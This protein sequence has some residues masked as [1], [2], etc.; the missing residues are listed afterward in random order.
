LRAKREGIDTNTPPGGAVAA[1]MA[2]L[3]V[4][5][6]GKERRDAAHQSRRDRN[7]PAGKPHKLSVER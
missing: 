2:S 5:E 6:L 1:I 7:L 4:L 3:A